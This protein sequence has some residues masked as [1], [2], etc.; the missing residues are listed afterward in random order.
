[1]PKTKKVVTPVDPSSVKNGPQKTRAVLFELDNVAVDG[2]KIA[3]NV[4]KEILA[5]KGVKITLPM[6]SRYGITSSLKK[7]MGKLLESLGKGRLSNEKLAADIVAGVQAAFLNE[8]LTVAPGVKQIVKRATAEGVAVGVLSCLD[9]HTAQ[10]LMTKLQLDEGVSAVLAADGEERIRF[11]V[12]AWRKLAR[13]LSVSPG[14]C[15]VL[16]TCSASSQAA[17]AA[18]MRCVAI[19]DLYTSFQDFG[20]ADYVVDKLDD[21][22]IAAVFSLLEDR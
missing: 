7:S 4:M 20:G 16:A 13:A 9:R 6:F 14:A 19:P 18:G 15:V 22:A 2:R 1:M 5:D 8:P 12:E 17:I 11:S 10:H 21:E 3:F